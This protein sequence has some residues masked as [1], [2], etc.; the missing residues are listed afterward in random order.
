MAD[1]ERVTVSTVT[2]E[3]PDPGSQVPLFT[4]EENLRRARSL[5]D[6]AGERGSD[7]CLLPEV[8]NVKRTQNQLDAEAVPGG[9]TSD[10]LSAAAKRW[11]MYVIGGLIEADGDKIYNSLALFD[12][13]GA[14]MGTVR[15]VHLQG[16][17]SEVSPGHSYPV[18]ETD[19]GT[20]GAIICID[21]HFPETARIEVIKGA[22]IIFWPT[23]YAEPRERLNNI[24]MKARAVEN[25]IFMVSSNYSQPCRDSRGIHIGGSAVVDPYGEILASTGRRQGVATTV[26]DLDAERPTY[27]YKSL[28][29]ARRVDTFGEILGK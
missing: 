20:I 5:L 25:A 22:E 15:K 26:I 27:G 13:E 10:M 18:F 21:L 29:D 3:L 17:G 24:I 6:I 28:L 12:R 7:I 11:R 23:M 2:I 9:V 14:C 1:R 8:F 4:K 19:F 16:P